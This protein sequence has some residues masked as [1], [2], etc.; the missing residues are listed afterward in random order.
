MKIDELRGKSREELKQTLLELRREQF[1]LR[2]QQASGQLAQTDQ[3]KKVRRDIARVK[4]V[5]TDLH[6]AAA[7]E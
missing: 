4:T 6:N 2:M 1:N 7:T 5:M 3:V